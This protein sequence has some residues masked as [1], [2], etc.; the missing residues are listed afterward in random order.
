M[1]GSTEVQSI[2][3]IVGF[4]GRSGC[5]LDLITLKAWWACQALIWS[6]K[7]ELVGCPGLKSHGSDDKGFVLPRCYGH[8]SCAI[9]AGI[10]ERRYFPLLFF[11]PPPF[12]PS[13]ASFST[14]TPSGCLLT[15]D[16]SKGV[17]FLKL[18]KAIIFF[19]SKPCTMVAKFGNSPPSSF[20]D[21]VFVYNW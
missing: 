21:P 12:Y 8:S 13:G 7:A 14:L 19:S 17:L 18:L 15:F 20:I 9:T 3:F 16:I 10:C 6:A 5:V 2:I 4:R 1:K 11:F